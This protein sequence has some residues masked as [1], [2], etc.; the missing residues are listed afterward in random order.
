M[1]L[2]II[3]ITFD[4]TVAAAHSPAARA[5][6]QP[7]RRRSGWLWI[8]QVTRQ[9]GRPVLRLRPEH[10]GR[11]LPQARIAGLCAQ[12]PASPP[13]TRHPRGPDVVPVPLVAAPREKVRRESEER[14]PAA[15][16][17]LPWLCS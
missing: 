17:A 14:M 3:A 5:L 13:P 11:P 12:D 1:R 6:D 10:Q 15:T 2:A 7:A 8:F 16:A 9:P 4:E